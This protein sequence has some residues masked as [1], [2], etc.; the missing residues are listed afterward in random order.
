RENSIRAVL[1]RTAGV[2]C[3]REQLWGKA[4]SYLNESLQVSKQPPTLVA[5][6]R[7]A[8]AVGDDAEAARHYREAALGFVLP[9]PAGPDS[10]RP[11][12][13]EHTL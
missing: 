2:L 7:L 3:L 11:V 6:A 5:L 1:L 8:E 12:L 9:A 10:A 4:G 13:R